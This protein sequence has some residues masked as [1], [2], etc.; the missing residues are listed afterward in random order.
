MIPKSLRFRLPLTYAG[1]ALIATLVLGAVLLLTLQQVY[2]QQEIDYLTGNA[3]AISERVLPLVREG[4]LGQLQANVEGMAFLS[5]TRVQVFNADNTSQMADSGNPREVD[6]STEINVSVEIDGV[7]QTFE[8]PV[9]NSNAREV[10][11]TTIVIEPG[12]FGSVDEEV[13]SQLIEEGSV[14][15]GVDVAEE[16]ED[17][18]GVIT[19]TTTVTREVVSDVLPVVGTQFGFGFGEQPGADGTVS[20]LAVS[21]PIVDENGRLLGR[22][23]LSQ[24]PAYGRDILQ[25]VFLGWLIASAVAVLLAGLAGWL[26]SRRLVWPLL[27]LTEVTT[28]MADGDLAARTAVQRQDE[29]G[30]LGSSFNKM[31][32]QV[33]G[34]ITTLRQFIADAAHELHTP[35]TALQTDLQTLG[36]TATAQE[37]NQA[38]KIERMQ[39]QA[40]RLQTLTDSLLDLSRIEANS[41]GDSEIVNLNHLLQ[42]T[43]ELF[44]S[45][46]E[47]AD[48]Q[49]GL[50]L[51][52]LPLQVLGNPLRLRQ[53]VQNLLDNALK[54][55]PSGGEVA[56]LLAREDDFAHL[57]ITDTGIGIPDEDLPHLF[58]RFHRGRNTADFPG[59][60]LGL[61]IVQAIVVGMNGRIAINPLTPGTQVVVHLPI[62]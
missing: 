47:Q 33:E 15:E 2:R 4:D 32:D 37:P 35:L 25:S 55:T 60:G 30:T 59:N 49:F 40:V 62:S 41:N 3:F 38:A 48:I 13:K 29:L 31:A 46:A 27:T 23:E 18:T 22:V 20:N 57:T 28:R 51:P 43:A 24:G 44:A 54:F 61:A 34:T 39:A 50:T 53:A 7:E 45:R 12:L 17:A 21:R 56:V 1:I 6:S 19:R 52:D 8:Q 42:E 9:A 5:Q 10:T 11:E 14:E 58:G 26:V 16:V 36:Q